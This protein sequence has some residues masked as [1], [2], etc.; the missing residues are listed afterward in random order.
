MGMNKTERFC[1]F[2]GLVLI[3]LYIGI[4]SL[5]FLIGC[6][7]VSAFGLIFPFANLCLD[8]LI[9]KCWVAILLS[10]LQLTSPTKL[11]VS[12]DFSLNL[13]SEKSFFRPSMKKSI[14]TAN[15]QIYTDWV[16][17][18]YLFWTLNSETDIKIILKESLKK[19][20]LFGQA[21]MLMKF[22]FLKRNWEQDREY[23]KDTLQSFK[24]KPLKLL[25]FPE[26]T[27]NNETGRRIEKKYTDRTGH[28]TMEHVLLPRS[29]GLFACVSDLRQDCDALYDIT[30]GYSGLK[31]DDIPHRV[32]SPLK[33]I[34][35][36]RGPEE[37]HMHI[38]KFDIDDIPEDET[39]FS[40]WLMER[41]KEKNNLLSHFYS[42]GKFPGN[43][44]PTIP[45]QSNLRYIIYTIWILGLVEVL[46]YFLE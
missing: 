17:I 43:S 27:I 23:L 21:M 46:R 33:M 34:G 45:L 10:S 1:G 11:I 40:D 22:V 18:W 28:S 36:G 19:V 9:T 4:A 13:L 44:K 39:E 12:S 3:S 32:Y 38:R 37:T 2:I 6:F 31:P 30:I 25:I 24:T 20:P 14:I 26:G 35:L 29:K 42:H 41:F 8:R 5:F 15:H 16:Y 7:V